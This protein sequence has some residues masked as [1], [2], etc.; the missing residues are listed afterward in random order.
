MDPVRRKIVKTGTA[1]TAM[2]AAS[3]VFG[4]AGSR[5]RRP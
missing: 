5:Q 4:Q 3:R 2:A 1:A